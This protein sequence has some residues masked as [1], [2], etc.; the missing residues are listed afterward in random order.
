MDYFMNSDDVIKWKYFL[1]YCPFVGEFS[2]HREF[3]AQRPV[4]R[5]FD[6]FFICAWIN[7]WVSNHEA[8]YL[9]RNR[10]HY[11]VTLMITD[12][13]LFD[14]VL[15]WYSSRCLEGRKFSSF[16]FYILSNTIFFI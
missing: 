4:T 2:G 15:L 14:K 3:P 11:Y 12:L 10:V 5:S 6:G 16:C 8:G 1:R 9:R 7:G 13:R